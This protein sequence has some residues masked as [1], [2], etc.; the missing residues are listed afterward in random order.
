MN[1]RQV[2][3]P[4]WMSTTRFDLAAKLPAGATRQDLRQMERTLL[5]E[6]FHLRSH[7]ED[8]PYKVYDLLIAKGGLRV[9]PAPVAK[10]LQIQKDGLYAPNTDGPNGYATW[11]PVAGGGY[12]IAGS[13][14]MSVLAG[15]IENQLGVHVF[16][17]TGVD[18]I[19]DLK[20]RI[21]SNDIN[22]GNSNALPTIFDALEKLG[23][24]LEPGTANLPTL[25]VDSADKVPTEN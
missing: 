21:A 6:R 25:I 10:P 5:D 17:K 20:L 8:R 11:G 15:L 16:D 18:G 2:V 14:K 7:Y 4:E 12:D 3:T 19:Y 9:Q 24:R 13:I 22:V 1:T 23:L